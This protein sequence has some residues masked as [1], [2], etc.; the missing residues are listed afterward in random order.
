MATLNLVTNVC[1]CKS[2]RNIYDCYL[3][4]LTVLRRLMNVIV[5][6]VSMEPHVSIDSIDMSVDVALDSEVSYIHHPILLM[7]G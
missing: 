6:R 2:Y 7:T 1:H 4:D 5:T 3:Q